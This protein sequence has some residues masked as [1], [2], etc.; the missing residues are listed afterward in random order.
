MLVGEQNQGHSQTYTHAQ[1][2]THNN[3]K[4]EM[5]H[6]NNHTKLCVRNSG[7][8]QI[9]HHK[10]TSKPVIWRGVGFYKWVSQKHSK[11]FKFGGTAVS[12]TLI[13]HNSIMP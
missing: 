12:P 10:T 4:D 5:S 11:I 13:A 6:T 1:M 8:G 2:N 9:K 3:K 7:R